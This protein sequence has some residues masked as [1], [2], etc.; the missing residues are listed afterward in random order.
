MK[1]LFFIPALAILTGI[2]IG[3]FTTSDT[4]AREYYRHIDNDRDDRY[5]H[6][7]YDDRDDDRYDWDDRDD[8]DD[9][10]ARKDRRWNRGHGKVE[11]HIPPGHRVK[12]HIRY[13]GDDHDKYDRRLIGQK[14][15]YDND[16]YDNRSFHNSRHPIHR[17]DQIR[18]N[19]PNGFP[20]PGLNLIYDSY[21][22]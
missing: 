12:T 13:R 3:I 2:S 20:F 21:R 8:R 15:R 4:Q 14:Y 17:R 11:H 5:Y 1:N 7:R 18:A 19:Q 10:D 16:R 6:D 22:Y 9:D